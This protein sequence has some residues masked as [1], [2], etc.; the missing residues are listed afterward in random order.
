MSPASQLTI[1][2]RLANVRVPTLSLNAVDDPI[3]HVDTMEHTAK[4]AQHNENI[5]VLITQYGGH[6]GWPMGLAPSS[7]GFRFM[8]ETVLDFGES[9]IAAEAAGQATAAT[10]PLS[11]THGGLQ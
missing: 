2:D 10:P 9:A 4:Y 1:C 5:F 8:S 11:G 3:I 7:N 6:C